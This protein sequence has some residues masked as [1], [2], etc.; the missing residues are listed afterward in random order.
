MQLYQPIS[1]DS[2]SY[3]EDLSDDIMSLSDETICDSINNLVKTTDKMLNFIEIS[4]LIF[5]SSLS[6]ETC[7]LDNK[8]EIEMIYKSMI[9]IDYTTKALSRRCSLFDAIIIPENSVYFDSVIDFINK[10]SKLKLSLVEIK[11]SINNFYMQR[12]QYILL[13]EDVFNFRKSVTLH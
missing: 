7:K 8:L 5:S 4:S 12:H 3:S 11:T 2:L 9:Q 13:G 6:I 1:D 10:V